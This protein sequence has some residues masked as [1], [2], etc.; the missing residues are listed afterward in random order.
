MTQQ[1]KVGGKKV[2]PISLL[3]VPSLRDPLD[4][5]MQNQALASKLELYVLEL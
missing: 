1:Q 4:V 2:G 5:S 3:E